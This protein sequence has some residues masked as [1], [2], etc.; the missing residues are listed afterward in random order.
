MI[1][2]FLKP[3]KSKYSI[4]QKNTW[5]IELLMLNSN[6][7]KHLNVSKQ[8]INFKYDYMRYIGILET[9]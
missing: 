6:T 8:M 3:A 9:I 4:P 7:W 1:I 2:S 5:Y